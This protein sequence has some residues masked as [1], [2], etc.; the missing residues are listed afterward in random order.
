ML[1]SAV[2]KDRS[3]AQHTSETFEAPIGPKVQAFKVLEEVTSIDALEFLITFSSVVGMFG[4]AGQT[5]YARSIPH[6]LIYSE[7]N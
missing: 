6:T 4:N 2:L 7:P 5:N 1:L 3:F